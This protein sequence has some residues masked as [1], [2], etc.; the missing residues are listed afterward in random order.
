MKHEC[1]KREIRVRTAWN[2]AAQSEKHRTSVNYAGRNRYQA[3]SIE[4]AAI[5]AP[6]VS[7]ASEHARAPNLPR[8]LPSLMRQR[9]PEPKRTTKE[10][11]Y[12]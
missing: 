1:E 7:P 8:R 3:G 4:F 5:G 11:G 9:K 6:P 12:R 2:F 10:I